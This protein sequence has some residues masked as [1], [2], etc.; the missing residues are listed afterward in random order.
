M[1]IL[2]QWKTS[3]QTKKTSKK[4]RLE[5]YRNNPA[6]FIEKRLGIKLWSGMKIVIDSVWNNKRTS[7]RACHGVSKTYVAAAITVA[8]FNLYKDAIIVTTAPTSR[9]VELLL[10]K[11]IRNI[12]ARNKNFLRG[13]C[14]TVKI[15]TAG[16]SYV[17]GF[18]TDKAESI[19]GFH[20]PHILW[21]LD[22]AKGLPQWVYDAVEGSMTGGTSRVLEISTTDGAD[23]QCPLRQHQE[24]M[25]DKWNCI[26][27]SAFD[28]PF[29]SANEYPEFKQHR[30]QD[31]Y[32]Y[33]KPRKG[34]EWSKEYQKKIQIEVSEGI[35]DK[36]D[37]WFV[38]EPSMWETKVLG[39]FS[40][41][42][43]DN[44]IPLKW[45]LSAVEAEVDEGEGITKHGFDVA[46][47]G[48]DKC[49][50]TTLIGKTV[51]P[52]VSWGKKKIPYSVGRIMAETEL[53]EVVN[54]DACGM[55][56]G[57]FDDLAEE[58]HATI[59]LDS[60]SNAFDVVKFKNLRAE[61]WWNARQ[62]FE[63]QYEEGNVLSIPDDPELIMDLTGLQYK[64]ML[65]GQYIMEPK[66]G[67]K[68]RLKRSPDKGDSFVYCIYDP[69]V[70]EEEYYG[71]SD[72]EQ[73]IFL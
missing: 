52:Q 20:S 64:P 19:E 46:R 44:V 48:D 28:S 71:E 13:E 70:F 5:F 22:E 3:L 35:L 68:K 15:K 40:S 39:D 60:A 16:D 4:D 36:K 42:G 8:F 51:Q 14:M 12:Y 57:V 41:T 65:S 9:Q 58:G 17:V 1:Q 21:I 38:K 50:L 7:V 33:G 67:Y 37:L 53:H 69:P 24:T 61:I 59:G 10:W 55:G 45:V 31:L 34:R 25:R 56:V 2:S 62:V 49:I 11:E 27:L 73:D 26:K 6:V 29:V 54:V 23:Q 43:T 47:M 32:D 30:N 72:D 18:S 63:K 66:D